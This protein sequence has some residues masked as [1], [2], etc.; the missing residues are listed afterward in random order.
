MK[1]LRPEQVTRYARH[2]LLDDVGPA[3]Q[4]QLLAGCARVQG[5]GVAAE[6]A[7]RYLTAAGVG[8][9]VLAPALRQR[10]ADALTALN[11]DTALIDDADDALPVA[12]DDPT[13]RLTGALAAHA[14]LAQL[15]GAVDGPFTWTH[16]SLQDHAW[17]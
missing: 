1:P 3:G 7:A 4:L 16:L 10:L 9:L 2:L 12:P 14:A 5:D 13:S 8:R 17:H 11:P 15:S 6:E